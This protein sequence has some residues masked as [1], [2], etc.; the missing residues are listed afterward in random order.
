MPLGND[1]PR[2]DGD[3]R[4][5]DLYARSTCEIHCVP[6]SKKVLAAR[7]LRRPNMVSIATIRRRTEPRLRLKIAAMRVVR[8][9]RRGNRG[10]PRLERG[11]NS[12]QD[13]ECGARCAEETTDH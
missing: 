1:G 9:E 5:Q 13:D 4:C 12:R 11:Q 10:M 6:P 7:L 3:Q 8:I 2:A